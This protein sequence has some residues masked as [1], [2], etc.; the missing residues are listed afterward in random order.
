MTHDP[1]LYEDQIILLSL[2][3]LKGNEL[4]ALEEHLSGGCETC[5]RLLAEN[6]A[7]VS[8]IPY[9]LEDMRLS[10]SVGE[11][12]FEAI[13]GAE[14][15]ESRV[16]KGG[17]WSRIEPAW[18]NFG[19]AVAAAAIIILVLVNMSLRDDRHE[20]QDT[21]SRLQAE[22]DKEKSVMPFVMDTGVAS[23]SL[24]GQM[25]GLD[26]SGKLLWKESANKALLVVSDVPVLKPGTTYQFWCIEEG[27]P[28]SMGT[29]TVNEDGSYMMEI[30]DMPEKRG[31]IKFLVTM[32]PE[33]GMPEPTGQTY[34]AGST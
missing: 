15:E 5:E 2:G 34:L 9:A 24:E 32:E 14:P 33:G 7:V 13:E 1:N 20:L 3:A 16:Q 30:E 4:R 26:S 18:L 8:S 17:F 12:I 28:H 22:L 11:R 31:G 27:K 6:Q 23:V 10:D 29:F 25:S 19:S 21:V